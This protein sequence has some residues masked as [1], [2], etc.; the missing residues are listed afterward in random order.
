M[1]AGVYIHKKGKEHHNF[2]R[3]HSEKSRKNMSL[4]RIGIKLSEEH[5]RK[6]SEA[7]AKKVVL[8]CKQCGKEF[9]ELP[10]WVKRGRKYCSHECQWKSLKGRKL[11]AEIISKMKHTHIGGCKGG[12]NMKITEGKNHIWKGDNVGYRALH[13]WVSRWLS[14]PEKCEHCGKIGYGRQMHWA[15]KSGNYK[16]LISDWIRLCAKCHAKYDG[17]RGRKRIPQLE[18]TLQQ[19]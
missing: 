8:I 12:H 10:C 18:R 11:S 14:K 5:K 3:K 2:G 16:R 13:H 6:I 19:N 7:K 9:L 15:N 4:A 1:P 17:N